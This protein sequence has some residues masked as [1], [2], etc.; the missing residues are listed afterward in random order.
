MPRW[1]V[2]KLITLVQERPEIWDTRSNIYLDRTRKDAAWEQVARS[3]RKNDWAKADSRGRADLVKQTKTRWA[4][5][6]DQFRREV[7]SKGRSGEG[8]SRKRPYIYTAQLQFLRPVMD[9]RPTVDSLEPSVESSTDG[10]ETPAVFSPANSPEPTPAEEP[11]L[12]SQGQH[13]QPS[14]PRV[15]QPHR[16]RP[17]QVP[18]ST[19]VP[20]SR[21]VIDARVIDFL[22]QRRS[23]GVEEKMLRGLAPLMKKVPEPDHNACVASIAV[24]MKMFAIPNHGDILGQLNRWMV[25]LEKEGQPQEAGQFGRERHPSQAPSFAPQPQY[26]PP[27]GH[28][29]GASQ[30]IFQGN[31]PTVPQQ[32]A[33]GRP[34]SSFPAGSFTQDLF[35]L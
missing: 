13:Q 23:D 35:E 28:F 33:Q 19:S 9:L 15:R 34:R 11:E 27:H 31:L 20:E 16:R 7:S 32:Q 12:S 30:P 8:P 10:S 4:S 2:E 26:G 3:L 24:V 17:R 22:A 25:D 6:R 29:Q 21:E 14:P 5:C 18:P 1:N